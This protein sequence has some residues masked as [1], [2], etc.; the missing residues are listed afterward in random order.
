MQSISELRRQIRGISS[1][2]KITRTMKMV[3][4]ARYNKALSLMHNSQVFYRELKSTFDQLSSALEAPQSRQNLF[5]SQPSFTD[6]RMGVI[7]MTSDKGLCGD[8]NTGI[9]K[10]AR[11]FIQEREDSVSAVFAVGRKAVNF[12]RGNSFP[13]ILEYPLVTTGIE[14]AFA[15]K[16]GREIMKIFDKEKLTSIKCISSRFKS[17]GK[18]NVSVTSLLPLI[19]GKAE[20]NTDLLFEPR[21]SEEIFGTLIPLIFKAELFSLLQ[22]SHVS[23]LSSRITA[24]DNA[25]TNAGV[26]I[27]EITLEMNKTRQSAITREIAEIT[28]TNEVLK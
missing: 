24:M 16:I 13:L 19:G 8:F 3:A 26:L 5:A 28:G 15:D 1:T 9:L 7:I 20:E 25:T 6:N 27:D 10:T 4:S 12:V 11:K 18:I 21:N 23:E 2:Q 14:F 17:R 22:E